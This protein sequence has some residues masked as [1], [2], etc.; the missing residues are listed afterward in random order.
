MRNFI[1]KEKKYLR[2]KKEDTKKFGLPHK[3]RK[4]YI[5][6]PNS[7]KVIFNPT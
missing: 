3:K 7:L 5:P 4:V 1:S 6:Q 2:D